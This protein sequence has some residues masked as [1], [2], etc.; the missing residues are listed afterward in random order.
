M[1]VIACVAIIVVGPKDLPAMLRT[2]GKAIGS[3]KRMAGDFQRQVN[4][5]IKEADLDG[6]KDLTSTKG[7]GPLED[8]K[9]SMEEFA[10]TMKDPMEPDPQVDV[11]PPPPEPKPKSARKPAA[12]KAA[13]KKTVAKKP[14]ARTTTKA[15]AATS[16]PAKKPVPRKKA[17][18]PKAKTK[19]AT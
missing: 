1:L 9:K 10:K 15:A 3:V 18:T 4:D 19:S 14:A 7:F 12:K 8:A 2:F 13:P 11:A 5:A 6:V 17:G 16:P